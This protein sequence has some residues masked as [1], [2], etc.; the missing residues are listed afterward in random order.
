MWKMLLH[1][2]WLETRSRFIWCLALTMASISH[3]VLTAPTVI[4]SVH[5][6]L[7]WVEVS[8]ASYLWI[9]VYAGSLRAAWVVF[10]VIMAMGG[11]RREE[12]SGACAFTLSLPI[13]RS[14]FLQSQLAVGIAESVGFGFL[15][16]MLIPGLS[17]LVTQTYPLSQAL[18]HSVLLVGAGEVLYGWAFL[19]S[20]MTQKQFGALAISLGSIGTFFVLVKRIRRLDAFDIFDIMT[21]ADLLDRHT[22]MLHGPLPWLSLAT[23]ASLFVGMVWISILFIERHDF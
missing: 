2:S 23:I 7:P 1:K 12:A 21:G 11:L 8:F 6:Q 18:L 16:A 14:R 17:S 22:F 15:P 4:Q 3:T 20:Q 5:H 19:V 13:R 9:D 10:V